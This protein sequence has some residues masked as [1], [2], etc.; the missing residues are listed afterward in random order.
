MDYRP[1]WERIILIAAVFNFAVMLALASSL[2]LPKT[3]TSR[4]NLQMIEW[5]DSAV[6]EV[7]AALQEEVQTFP[8]IKLTPLEIPKFEPIPPPEPVEVEKIETPI[9]TPKETASSAESKPAESEKPVEN[10]KPTEPK[11]QEK[12]SQSKLIA[13]VKVYPRDLTEQ[14]LESGVV[15][16]KITLNDEKIIVAVTIGVDGKVKSAEIVSGAG[17]DERGRIINFVS[18]TAASSWIFEPYLDEDGNPVELQT[19]LEFTAADF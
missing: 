11:P 8:E 3:E 19:Q 2:S 16:E 18:Q 12:N 5:T 15:K 17:D 1:R 10:E 9:E 14:F 6:D 13:I 4:E 7:P